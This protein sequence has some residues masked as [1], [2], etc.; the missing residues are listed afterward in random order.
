MTYRVGLGLRP[1]RV[2]FPLCVGAAQPCT[3]AAS[4]AVASQQQRFAHIEV[5]DFSH[6]RRQNSGV[7]EGDFSRRAFTYVLTGG[8]GVVAAHT[9][10]NVVQDFLDTMSTSVCPRVR[11]WRPGR[12]LSALTVEIAARD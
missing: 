7:P 2:L 12:P 6:Y 10:K 3:P 1:P 11:P 9:A 4:L 8:V 5:P